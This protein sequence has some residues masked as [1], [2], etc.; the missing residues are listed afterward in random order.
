MSVRT[1]LILLLIQGWL[2][3]SAGM[4][5]VPTHSVSAQE[6]SWSDDF[7]DGNFDDWLTVSQPDGLFDE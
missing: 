7:Q 6:L 5:A 2:I 3:G 4:T 1:I